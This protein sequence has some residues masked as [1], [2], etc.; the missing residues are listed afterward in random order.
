M[1]RKQNDIC[2]NENRADKRGKFFDEAAKIIRVFT[3]APV[4]SFVLF[5][6]LYF[7]IPGLA[8]HTEYFVTVLF[9]T[10]LPLCAYPLHLAVPFLRKKGR[11]GQRT[12]AMI[13]AYAGYLLSLLYGV[14][15]GV[16]RLLLILYLAYVL[17]CSI[18]LIIDK[19]FGFHAS[20][21]ACGLCGPV[22]E[23]IYFTGWYSLI[24]GAALFALVLWSSLRMKRHT[25]PQFI[26]GGAVSVAV[27]L[28]LAVFVI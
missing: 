12:L 2:E 26:L 13:M 20:G 11:H 8:T 22:A 28:L 1:T 24:W 27:F 6:V 19:L 18:L 10:A 4:V 25:V 17:S 23:L 9:Y 7:V 5:T 16:S 14:V 21:H 3:T 15:A